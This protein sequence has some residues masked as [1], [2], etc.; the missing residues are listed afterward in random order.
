MD[1]RIGTKR[2]PSLVQ[3]GFTLPELLIVLAIAGL[4]LV[5]A[6]PLAAE[7]IRTVQNHA[8][9]A[10]LATDIRAARM[11]A[12]SKRSAVTL[13]VDVDP[14]NAYQYTDAHG[15]VRRITLPKQIRIVS[16]SAPIS[17][18]ATGALAAATTT[19]LEA[20]VSGGVIDRFTVATSLLGVPTV[21]H[22][23]VYP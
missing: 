12:V 19:V 9:A 18:S 5:I 14:T 7:Q 16:S 4:A 15:K 2:N 1:I 22:Q 8:A 10:Q 11:I 6:V 17:F 21:T 23:R 20:P 3:P 13:Q